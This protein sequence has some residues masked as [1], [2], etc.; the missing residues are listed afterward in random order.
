MV[1]IFPLLKSTILAADED[2]ALTSCS[3]ELLVFNIMNMETV[4]ILRFEGDLSAVR[5]GKPDSDFLTH[6]PLSHR[7]LQ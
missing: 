4:H 6:D 7:Q 3:V 1:I 2:E 5:V